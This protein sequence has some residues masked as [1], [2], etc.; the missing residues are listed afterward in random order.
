MVSEIGIK[1]SDSSG[2]AFLTSSIFAINSSQE[3]RVSS[4]I[5]NFDA[6]SNSSIV[7]SPTLLSNSSLNKP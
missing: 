2:E 6:I 3:R 1:E 5:S 7:N 4:G